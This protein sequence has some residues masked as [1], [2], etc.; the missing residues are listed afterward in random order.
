MAPRQT[1]TTALCDRPIA[2]APEWVHLLP[3]GQIEARDGRS[4]V[5]DNPETVLADFQSG[6]VDLP[7]DYE[8]QKDKHAKERTGPVPA[9]GW[10]KAL[11]LRADGIWGRVDWTARARDLIANRE[12]RYLSPSILFNKANRQIVRLKGAG[13]VHD[14]ALHL[15]ALASQ[16]DDMADDTATDMDGDMPFLTRL[17]KLLKLDAD[18]SEDDILTA[19]QEALDGQQKPDPAKYVPIEALRDMMRDRKAS[20]TAARLERA[21]AKVETALAQGYI[22]PAMKSW[23]LDLCTSDEASFDAFVSESAPAAYAHLSRALIPSALPG[24]GKPVQ[25]PEEELICQQLGIAPG[26]L[27]T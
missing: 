3:L 14:P 13:L 1:T 27:A 19:L 16:E 11:Q 12:Y 5:L 20:A 24:D 26:E 10:I 4:F 17:A 18:A 25:S 23:A 8:H 22:I 15:T 9:A 6:A 7:V 21:E 2:D